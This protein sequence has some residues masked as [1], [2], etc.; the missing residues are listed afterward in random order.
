[1]SWRT[2]FLIS[3][4]INLLVLGAVAGYGLNGGFNPHEAVVGRENN[5]AA[6]A[7][8]LRTLPP[9]SR[10]QV[11]RALAQGWR[12]TQTERAA[13]RAARAETTRLMAA[14][15]YDPAAVRSALAAQ[16]AASERVVARLHERLAESIGDLTPEQR[17]QLLSALRSRAGMDTL[18]TED[19][20]ADAP[21]ERAPVAGENR[22]ERLR[23]RLRERRERLRGD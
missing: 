12:D 16:R 10:A 2:A 6:P 1:M 7:A 15:P 4:A 5:V 17:S 21:P 18:E 19:L 20:D 9:A 8:V 11:R 23:E 14:E 13:M 22:R 3:L